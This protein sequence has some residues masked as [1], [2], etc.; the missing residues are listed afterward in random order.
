MNASGEDVVA[1]AVVARKVRPDRVEAYQAWQSE[2]DEATN[3]SPGFLGTET[4]RPVP[5]I[6]EDWVIIF[7]FDSKENLALWMQSDQR[8]ELLERGDELL[9]APADEHTMVG[10][11]PAAHS[12]TLIASA[13]PYPGREAQFLASEKALEVAA[14]SFGGFTGYELLE[15]AQDAGGAWT[16]LY[17]FEDSWRADEWLRSQTRANLM[18]NLEKQ[19]EQTAIRKV[20]S[21]FGSWFSF[22]EVDGANTPNWKQSM[23]VLLMLYP[24]IMCINYLTSYLARIGIP[25]FAQTFTSNVLSTVALGF[26]LMPFATRTLSFWLNPDATT[27]TTVRGAVLVVALYG[28]LLALWAL[29][30]L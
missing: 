10:G 3:R 9:E 23:T 5:G 11:T 13:T 20:P 27:R 12:V 17:R 8:R 29:V 1:T 24:T 18:E 7:R 16:S 25:P 4:I 14:R 19:V 15:P 26:V 22:N 30:T 6:H 21:A 28:V 2:I